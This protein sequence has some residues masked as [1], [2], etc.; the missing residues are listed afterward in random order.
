M[1]LFKCIYEYL[2]TNDDIKFNI[3]DEMNE[4]KLLRGNVFLRY[5]LQLCSF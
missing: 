2:T 1:A 3:L 5:Q 4:Q